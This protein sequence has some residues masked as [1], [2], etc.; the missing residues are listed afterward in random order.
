ME[1]LDQLANKQNTDK[2][3]AYGG[4]SVHGY[5]DIYETYLHKW[6]NEN[7]RLLEVG[8][9]MEFTSGGHSLRMWHEYF[10]NAEIFGFD[11][12][13]MKIMEQELNRVKIFQGDQT[14]RDDFKRMYEYFGN[15]E[16]DLIVEDGSHVHSHQMIS[17]GHL[18]QYVKSGGIYILE[19]MTERDVPACCIRNDDTFDAIKK[20]YEIGIIDSG[21]LTPE[22]KQYIEL[23]T[24]K[25]DIHKDIKDNYRV[26]II[27]KK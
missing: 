8:I 3:S 15:K 5:A 21:H 4:A 17:F 18:F 16:F 24:L 12:V 9:C 1:T 20:L 13:D 23:N 14:K 10:Q 6:R 27:H 26:A 25:V 2:G 19:D 11:I 22:E 7:I